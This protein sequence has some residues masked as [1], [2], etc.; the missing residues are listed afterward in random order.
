MGRQENIMTL[1]FGDVNILAVVVS[2]VVSVVIGTFWFNVPF[3]FK[4][5]WLGRVGK[6]SEQVA[7]DFSLLKPLAA[8]IGSLLTAFLLAVLI[9]WTGA[10]TL[11]GG[12]LI[13]LL[14]GVAFSAMTNGIRDLFE[15]RPAK[16]TLINAGHDVA[17]LVAMGAIIG[18]WH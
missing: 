1:S 7:A 4:E 13:G 8:L 5:A 15:G 3:L 9:R 2:A 17:V 11:A 6:T 16:L 14:A 18:A 12:A 10:T